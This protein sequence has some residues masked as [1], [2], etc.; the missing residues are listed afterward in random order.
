[1]KI[2]ATT[3]RLIASGDTKS[4]YL[5]QIALVALI[6][7]FNVASAVTLGKVTK[8]LT[9]EGGLDL[10]QNFSLFAVTIMI[11]ALLDWYRSVRMTRLSEAA[12]SNYRKRTAQALLHAEYTGIQ[13]LETGDLISRVVTDCRFAAHNSELM[14]D[15]LRNMLVPVILIAVMF[16]VDWRVALG[17]TL[18]FVPVFIYPR[19]TKN[20]LSEIPAY[21][22]AF[23]AMN[24]QAKDLIQNRTTVM[25]YRLQNKADQWVDEV[26]EDYR[27]KG[28]KGIGK[29]YTSNIP[30]LAIN[31]LPLFGCTI[32]GAFLLF[33]GLFTADGFV[34]A[35]MLASVATDELLKLPNIMVN[36][37]SG[38]VAAARLFEL[39]DLPA[40]KGGA[41]TE[42]KPGAAVEFHKVTFR[43][44]EQDAAE[45]PLLDELSFSVRQGEKVA[46]VG[47]SGCGKSTVLR[48]I[49]GL[50]RPQSGTVS[51]LGREVEEWNLESLRSRMSVLQ[52]DAFVFKGSLKDNILLGN[53]E[54]DDLTLTIAVD[55]AKLSSWVGQQPEGWHADAGERGS[56]LSGGLRQR[57]GLARLFLKNAPIELMDEATSALDSNHQKEILQSLRD[58]GAGKTRI[59]IAHRLSTVTDSDR[60]LFLY[61]GRIAEEGTHAELLKKRGLYYGLYTAQE[62]EAEHGGE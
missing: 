10:I 43:Y 50:Y 23:A 32:V 17:Y 59:V 54:A 48:L 12:E 7:L 37:P 29:I 52:Q 58:S 2:L 44:A 11:I 39:W 20:S 18:P 51:V 35:I 53:L 41:E 36:F 15:G 14:I 8:S 27:R 33:R 19:L 31:V 26:V 46:L 61:Q 45:R 42:A 62:K 47:H 49:T 25:A 24:G 4:H 5:L 16:V 21:R 28:V 1:M 40:E 55:H 9:A 60:I 3:R 6:G 34:V 30:A 22:K 57:V 38:I 13:K 56:R